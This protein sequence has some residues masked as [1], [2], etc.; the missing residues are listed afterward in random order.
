[1]EESHPE[2][3]TSPKRSKKEIRHDDSISKLDTLYSI[4]IGWVVKRL[5]S[6]TTVC[7]D[8]TGISIIHWLWKTY[9]DYKNGKHLKNQRVNIDDVNNW[10]EIITN[11]L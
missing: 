9:D 6:L 5:A 7:L 10:R 3:S 8:P 2:G 11:I 1:M 4:K